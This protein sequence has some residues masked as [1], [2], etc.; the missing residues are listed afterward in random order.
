MLD[1]SFKIRKCNFGRG[2]AS[3]LA[4]GTDSALED[5]GFGERYGKRKERVEEEER[6]EKEGIWEER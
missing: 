6:V 1:F 5:P 3:H 4:G 2:S